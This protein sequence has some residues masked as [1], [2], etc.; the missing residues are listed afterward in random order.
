MS[1]RIKKP[2]SSLY[3]A[4]LA[5][6]GMSDVFYSR[7]ILFD[8]QNE[9]ETFRPPMLSSPFN[10]PCNRAHLKTRF[11]QESGSLLF[12]RHP[13][14]LSHLLKRKS[15]PRESPPHYKCRFSDDPAAWNVS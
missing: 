2:R 4:I 14:V 9:I 5:P 10:T 1:Q 8:G 11:P 3:A 12:L 7:R 6:D 15:T 13:E